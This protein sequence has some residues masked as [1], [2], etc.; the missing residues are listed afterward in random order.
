MCMS[1]PD[2]PEPTRYSEA[3]APVFR[4]QTK[5]KPTGRRGTMLT[6]GSGAMPS[7]SGAQGKTLLGQ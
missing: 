5:Q 4:D 2:V 3:K 6:G 7:M 1:S